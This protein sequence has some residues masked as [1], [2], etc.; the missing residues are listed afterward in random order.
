MVYMFDVR[1]KL[2]GY[3]EFKIKINALLL[4]SLASAQNLHAPFHPHP[5]PDMHRG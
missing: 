3:M 4:I 2:R 1:L 5:A